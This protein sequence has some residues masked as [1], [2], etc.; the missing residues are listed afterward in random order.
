V[1]LVLTCAL[2]ACSAA[3]VA[4]TSG[5]AT[6]AEWRALA[7]PRPPHLPGAPRVT[8]GEIGLVGSFPWPA[9]AAV[10]PSLGV[11]ELVAAGLLRRQD[12]H[13]VERR[14]FSAAV[15]AERAGTPAAG[16]PRAGVSPGAELIVSAVWLALDAERATVELRVATL[17]TGAVAGTTRLSVSAAA[18]PVVLSRA[19]V[20]G[21]LEALEA[22][23]RLPD[24][25][26]SAIGTPGRAP[27]ADAV[28][29]FLR[30]LAAEE[31]WDWE[32]ARRG[33]QAAASDPSFV[34]ARAALARTARLRQGGTL[35][36]G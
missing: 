9:Q 10:A 30:G 26:E 29:S 28:V 31:R 19:I 17:A 15:E 6:E 1:V 16:A 14:R 32:D 3:T 23:G 24:W 27:D 36:E 12:V 20:Q 22:L 34:E 35:G 8:I 13:F 25:D 7:E 11:A 18:D 33:Y 2:G 5:V 21:L 4:S